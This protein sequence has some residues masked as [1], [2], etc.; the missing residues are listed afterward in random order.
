M[1]DT[2]GLM[3]WRIDREPQYHRRNPV[4]YR[5]SVT[6]GDTYYEAFADDRDVVL[7]GHEAAIETVKA[8][9]RRALTT[10]GEK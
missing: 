10:E 9:I 5:V 4:A 1:S 6:V 8:S 2:P 3:K 7:V